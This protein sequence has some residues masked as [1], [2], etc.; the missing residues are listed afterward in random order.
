MS[1]LQ[2]EI[3]YEPF[4]ASADTLTNAAITAFNDQI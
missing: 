3:V 4:I 2:K 1:D